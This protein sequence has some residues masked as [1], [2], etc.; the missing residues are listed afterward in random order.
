MILGL[1]GVALSFIV[2][3]YKE[4]EATDMDATV[5]A[6]HK[7]FAKGPDIIRMHRFV[8][9]VQKIISKNLK[10]SI[11]AIAFNRSHMQRQKMVICA[12]CLI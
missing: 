1:L 5:V 11:N 9:K 6:K 10:K 2:K 12:K 8:Q 3:V 4:L 7:M